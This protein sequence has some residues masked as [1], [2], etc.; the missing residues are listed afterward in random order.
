MALKYRSTEQFLK[1]DPVY[2]SK[3]ISKFVNCLMNDGK[4][5]VAQRNFYD[6]MDIVAAKLPDSD[7][8]EVFEQAIE[9]IKPMLEVRSRR[10]GGMTYQVPTEV[11][12]KRQLSLAIRWLLAAAR[13]KKGRPMARR[14]AD[15]VLDAYNKQGTAWT[16]REN[17]HKMAEA[18]KAFAHFSI[19]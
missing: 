5:S 4:K 10:V 14:L 7:P 2:K 11:A 19:R 3:L 16:Q 17:T 15:E 13:A 12:P 8:A 18:N 6:A 9:N 1:P